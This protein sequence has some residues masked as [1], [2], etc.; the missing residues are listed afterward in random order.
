MKQKNIALI[1]VVVFVSGVFSFFVSRQ[2]ISADMREHEVEVVEP[3]TTEFTQPSE[4]YFNAQ[5]V[6]PT[7]LIR[8]QEHQNPRPFDGRN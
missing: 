1:I 7:Y 4:R 5:S 2:L 3:I 6:N 8:I